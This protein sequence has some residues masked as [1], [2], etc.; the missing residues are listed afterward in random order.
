LVF[1]NT[2][3]ATAVVNAGLEPPTYDK[4][5]HVLFSSSQCTDVTG[6]G[7]LTRQQILSRQKTAILSAK[8]PF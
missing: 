3:T 5:M 6:I 4:T 2:G 8:S 1:L 7:T